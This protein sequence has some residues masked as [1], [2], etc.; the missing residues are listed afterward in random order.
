MANSSLA[1]WAYVPTGPTGPTGSA[2]GPTGPTGSGATGPTG[3]A[4]PTGPGVGAT[5]PTGPTG[6]AGPTGP[7]NGPTG[8]TG[9]GPTGATGPTGPGPANLSSVTDLS[10]PT[11]V[12]NYSPGLYA[13]GVTDR[14]LLTPAPGGSTITGLVAAVDGWAVYVYNQSTTDS[15]TFTNLSASSS[16]GNKFA[17]PQSTSAVLPPQTGAIWQYTVNQWTSS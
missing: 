16:A 15:I 17:C 14:L 10:V 13:G 4:G 8:P 2:G 9:A 5:G 11:T 3:S 6:I 1:G 12:N 7:A